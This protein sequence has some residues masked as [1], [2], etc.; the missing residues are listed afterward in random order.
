MGTAH[1]SNSTNKTLWTGLLQHTKPTRLF[2]L[3]YRLSSTSPFPSLNPFP[4]ALIDAIAGYRYLVQD[5]GFD[6]GNIIVSG[7]SAGGNLAYALARYMSAKEYGH[8]LPR[9]GAVLLLSPTVD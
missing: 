3:S 4:A 6:P 1:P 8:E 2:A 7:D 5:V 9:P